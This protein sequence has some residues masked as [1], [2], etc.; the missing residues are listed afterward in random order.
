MLHGLIPDEILLRAP[1]TFLPA[2]WSISLEWQFYLLAPLILAAFKSEARAMALVAISLVLFVTFKVGLLGHYA[3]DATI[4][5]N[6]QYF[7]LGIVS[8]LAHDRLSSMSA[9]P[10]LGTAIVLLVSAVAIRNPLALTIWGVFYSYS[11]WHRNAPITG[12]VFRLLTQSK[13]FQILGE[14]SYSLYLIH[15]PMQVG[16]ISL[17]M[18]SV[19]L[20]QY[21]VL[22]IQIAATVLALPISVLLYLSVEKWGVR[23]GHRVANRFRANP[24]AMAV[25][26]A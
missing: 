4:A 8:R 10:L 15:R 7:L 25:P 14:A 3:I 21:S 6:I 23:M 24:P 17:L 2:A 20:T 1:M 19:A 12:Q 26:A 13:P 16:L 5:A 22:A 11:L 9:S 18:G